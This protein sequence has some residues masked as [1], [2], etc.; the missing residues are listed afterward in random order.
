MLRDAT[1]PSS[2][3]RMRCRREAAARLAGSQ[4]GKCEGSASEEERRLYDTTRERTG[5]ERDFKAS[6]SSSGEEAK[7]PSGPSEGDERPLL[8]LL[9]LDGAPLRGWK[10]EGREEKGREEKRGEREGRQLRKEGPAWRMR[11]A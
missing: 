9:E 3:A 2:F 4:V 7:S 1:G 11:K 6:C 5:A 10:R 8:E